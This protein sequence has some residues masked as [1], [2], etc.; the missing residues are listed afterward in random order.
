MS[1][2]N[3][4]NSARNKINQ[5]RYRDTDQ[6]LVAWLNAEQTKKFRKLF[7]LMATDLGGYCKSISIYWLEL[8]Y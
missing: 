2:I 3:L 1:F 8:P 7:D 6:R 4:E 5:S